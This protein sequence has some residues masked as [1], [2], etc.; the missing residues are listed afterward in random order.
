MINNIDS[1]L[2]VVDSDLSDLFSFKGFFN[3]SLVSLLLGLIP[4]VGVFAYQFLNNLLFTAW[5][6][7][8]FLFFLAWLVYSF[9]IGA[10]NVQVTVARN[11][12]AK[13][14][15]DF[16]Y[17]IELAWLALAPFMNAVA[18]IFFINVL[19]VAWLFYSQGIFLVVPLIASALLVY[20]CVSGLKG[21]SPFVKRT[22]DSKNFMQISQKKFDFLVLVLVVFAAV[23]LLISI[24]QSFSL[25]TNW[26]L[27]LAT[28]IF[29]AFIILVVASF[30]SSK[31]AEKK[32][33]QQIV[34]LL[35]LKD[36]LNAFR[37]SNEKITKEKLKKFMLDYSNARKWIFKI[38][39]FL[40]LKYYFPMPTDC[41]L[42]SITEPTSS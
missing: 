17:A 36:S 4:I 24:F 37:V 13:F 22:S 9:F 28:I 38:D 41:Y 21:M 12:L 35:K 1:L 19:V 18:L 40:F 34:L 15:G 6:P 33:E 32:I 39:N 14:K 30:L 16:D 3:N 27:V 31:Q 10:K 26:L 5:I 42:I 2:A 7:S 25:I 8:S 11:T 20:S 23:F 29:D